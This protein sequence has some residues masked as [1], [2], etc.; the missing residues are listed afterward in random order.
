MQAKRPQWKSLPFSFKATCVSTLVTFCLLLATPCLAQTVNVSVNQASSTLAYTV[1]LT[2]LQRGTNVSSTNYRIRGNITISNNSLNNKV[3]VSVNS[4]RLALT[5]AASG[6]TMMVNIGGTIG[7]LVPSTTA[8]RITFSNRSATIDIQGDLDEST[9]S[10]T[11]NSGS[12]SGK[13]I[14]TAVIL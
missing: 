8:N 14:I 13:L 1:T 3:Y 6:N 4:T 12:Y 2:D 10:L 11:T 5:N 7:N 9:L